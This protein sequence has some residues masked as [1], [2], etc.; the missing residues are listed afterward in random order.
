MKG[1]MD[2]M[3]KLY[4]RSQGKCIYIIRAQ[5]TDQ[6]PLAYLFFFFFFYFHLNVCCSRHVV[7]QKIFPFRVD[8]FYIGAKDMQEAP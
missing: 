8:R 5:H 3:Q 4:V 2:M 7:F 1:E 6:L